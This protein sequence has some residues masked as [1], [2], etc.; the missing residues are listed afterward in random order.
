MIGNR[1][2]GE[3]PDTTTQPG[4]PKW[5]HSIDD[6]FSALTGISLSSLNDS[7]FTHFSTESELI[8]RI[9][10]LTFNEIADLLEL[11]YLYNAFGKVS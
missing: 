8:E 2:R 6:D 4:V 5:L 1:I 7:G 11:V 9:E 3:L 10:R